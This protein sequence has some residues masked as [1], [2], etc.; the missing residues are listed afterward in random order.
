MRTYA[1]A[2]ATFLSMALIG[3]ALTSAQSI[4]VQAP[5]REPSMEDLTAAR[6]SFVEGTTAASE[7]R[8]ADA[9][10]LFIES[11]ELSGIAVSLVNV[12]MTYRSIGRYQLA[13]DTAQQV[14]DMHSD[15]GTDV[16][17]AARAVQE[18]VVSR[19][20][21]LEVVGLPTN[22]DVVLRVDNLQREDEGERPALL[23]VDEGEATLSVERAG[24]YPFNWEG[25]VEGGDRYLIEVEFEELESGTS[26]AGKVILVIAAVAV[27]AGASV[28][29][30]YLFRDDPIQG[31]G[32]FTIPLP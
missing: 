1:L 15:A 28:G 8:W 6:E 18:E 25:E 26:V 21:I 23:R 27:V 30:Y 24:H 32:D 17:G 2:V 16:L 4:V 14:L 11:Y 3:P 19:T 29:A 5:E 7:A 12:A 13:Y 20:A 9:L 31:E 22:E 10:D